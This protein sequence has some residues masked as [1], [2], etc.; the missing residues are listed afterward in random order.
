M[1]ILYGSCITFTTSQMGATM[2]PLKFTE[3]FKF[4]WVGTATHQSFSAISL[5]TLDL[6]IQL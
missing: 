6:F 2:E 5:W 4:I 3:D 1:I